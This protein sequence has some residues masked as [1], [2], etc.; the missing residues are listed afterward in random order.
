MGFFKIG[1]SLRTWLIL[2]ESDNLSEIS[3]LRAGRQSHSE[4]NEIIVE[5]G[6]PRFQTVRH[7]ELILDDQQAME[8][9]LCFEIQ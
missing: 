9:G 8:K 2:I 7:A 3:Q 4:V 1:S 6:H 5:K